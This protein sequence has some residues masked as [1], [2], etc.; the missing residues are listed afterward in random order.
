MSDLAAPRSSRPPQV[1]VVKSRGMER[2]AGFAASLGTV[3]EYFDFAIFGLLAATVF[4]TVFFREL[5]GA[6]ALMAS[7]ATYGV[8]FA[9]RPLGSVIF[10]T[11]G[12]RH[13]RRG[14]L[15]VTLCLMGLATVVMGLLPGYATIGVAAPA[16]LVVLRFVQGVASGGEITGAQLL[17]LEHAPQQRRGRA[18]SFVAIASPLAQALATLIL[19][20]LT[21]GLSKE[22]FVTWGWRIPLVASIV[23]VVFGAWVR[24]GVQETPE[25]VAARTATETRPNAFRVL[26]RYPGTIVILLLGYA[27]PAAIYP[28]VTTFGVSY[29]TSA[30]GLKSSTTFL[31]FLAAQLVAIGA[32][33]L[34]GRLADRIGPRNAMLAALIVLAVAFVPLFPVIHTGNIALIALCTTGVVGSVIIALSAQAAF[35]ADAFPVRM[36]YSGSS[37]AYTGTN[38]LFGGSAAV[39]ATALLTATGGNIHAVTLYGGIVLAISILAVLATVLRDETESLLRVV[40]L[41]LAGRHFPHPFL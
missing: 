6:T 39:V 16:I 35:Y 14:V 41:D 26:R 13:G 9:A 5:H 2:R 20:G 33:I 32:A 10:G 27:G 28:M 12:D 22:A 19:A 34:G 4:P 40:P 21:A 23:L 8:A 7:F 11:I 31:I 29:M 18:G 24:R 15:I 30:G 36:R 3:L 17:A 25:F 1:A 38:S 37:I